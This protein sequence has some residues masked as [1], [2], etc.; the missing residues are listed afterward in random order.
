MKESSYVVSH[1]LF[2]NDDNVTILCRF[3]DKLVYSYPFDQKEKK[4][5]IG[6]DHYPKF[7]VC[8]RFVI[9]EG[10]GHHVKL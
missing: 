8:P 1:L 2:F 7:S 5:K 6:C 10:R 9:V 4:K 3:T